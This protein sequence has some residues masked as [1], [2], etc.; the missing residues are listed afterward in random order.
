MVLRHRRRWLGIIPARAGFTSLH[1]RPR[2]WL[3]DHPRSRGVYLDIAASKSAA[4][5]SSPLARGLLPCQVVRHER[6]GIIP[7]RAGFTVVVRVDLHVRRD[8][9]RSRGV[10][11]GLGKPRGAVWG[12]SPLAR[13]LHVGRL[14]DGDRS[15]IIPARAGFTNGPSS[16]RTGSRDHPRSRGV[17]SHRR[18]RGGGPRGSSP[19][20]RGLHSS[21]R[22]DRGA[23]RIIPARAGFTPA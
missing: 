20:A 17:Y 18:S 21:W 19:L 4:V 10:Y 7:A 22:P 8:H 13:G 5:G 6:P 16:P 11:D 15:R 2:P 23:G 1:Y 14:G 3:R 9:P 12:S